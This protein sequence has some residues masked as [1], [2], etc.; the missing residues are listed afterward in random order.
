MSTPTL[1]TLLVATIGGCVHLGAV[2]FLFRWL[3][4][5]PD[6]LW[7]LASVTSAVFVFAFGFLVV[8]LSVHTRLLSPIVGLPTLLVWARIETPPRR[9]RSGQS[10]ADTSSLTVPST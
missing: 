3:S 9:R 5:V 6:S 8:L 10:L 2:E 1:R 7:P 4:H